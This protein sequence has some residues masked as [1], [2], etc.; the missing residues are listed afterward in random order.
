M[1]GT[2]E[3][4]AVSYLHN[5]HPH[6]DWAKIHKT[7]VDLRG[8]LKPAAEEEAQEGVI[9]IEEERR[10]ERFKP[11]TVRQ[12]VRALDRLIGHAD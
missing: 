10:Y 7:A 11:T 4:Y 3:G 12:T 6:V 8:M 2:L 5:E 1:R 9:E